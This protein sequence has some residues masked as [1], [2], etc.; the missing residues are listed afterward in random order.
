[1]RIIGLFAGMCSFV[2]LVACGGGSGSGNSSLVPPPQTPPPQAPPAQPPSA[3]GVYSGSTSVGLTFETI[4]LPNDRFYAI[5]GPG[6]G[7]TFHGAGIVMGQGTSDNGQYTASITD[8]YNTGLIAPG[9]VSASYVAGLSISGTLTETGLSE[10]FN[11]TAIPAWEFYYNTPAVLS[12][13]A[14]SWTGTL[15][16]GTT[17]YVT[18][19]PNGSFSGSDSGCSFAGTMPPDTSKNFFNVQMTFGDTPCL[20]PNQMATGVA[21]DYLLSDGITRQLLAGLTSGNF[22]TIFVANSG[23]V[24]PGSNA[25]T[26]LQVAPASATVQPGTSQQYTATATYGNNTTANV[27]S[28]VTWSTSPTS[29]ATI[30]SSGLLT[31]VALGTANIRA[32]SST[33]IIGTTAVSVATKQVTSVAIQP[34]TQTLSL[35]LGPTTVQYTATATYGDGSTANITAIATWTSTPSSVATISSTGLATAVAVGTA[36]V[37]AT[38]G[39]VTSNGAT[40]SVTP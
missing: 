27:T 21:V 4:V 18:I 32:T 1:M 22:G 34:L 33:G 5:Y 29:I 37:A 15:Q 25:I 7:N 6:S 14:G 8:Y 11:G 13:I 16:D 20:F 35:S 2:L 28:Q 9:S 24:L 30:N 26:A 40:V 23:Q 17:A 39:G 31:G 36:T 10:T 38:S 19:N 12:V 3:Q